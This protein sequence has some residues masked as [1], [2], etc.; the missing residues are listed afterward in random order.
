MENRV[1]IVTDPDTQTADRQVHD[2]ADLNEKIV[3]LQIDGVEYIV[4]TDFGEC[5]GC[6]S[7]YGFMA[8]IDGGTWCS[9][10]CWKQSDDECYERGIEEPVSHEVH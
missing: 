4:R 8:A 1:I 2:N 5:W 10:E 7:E 6:K 3:Y 9:H